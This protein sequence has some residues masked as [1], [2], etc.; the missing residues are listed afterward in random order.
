MIGA[1]ITL[2]SD[3]VM[4]HPGPLL[5]AVLTAMGVISGL[6]CLAIP[7]HRISERWL[8]GV[9]VLGTVEITISAVTIGRYGTPSRAPPCSLTAPTRPSP[10]EH[11]PT[12]VLGGS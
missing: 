2:P 4:G 5:V 9:A 6:G 1:T 3:L 7:W 10:A 11:F 12:S 8:D